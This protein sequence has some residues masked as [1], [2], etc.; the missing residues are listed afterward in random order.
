[1][2]AG[3]IVVADGDRWICERLDERFATE[4]YRV[5]LVNTA[6]AWPIWMS[7]VAAV[8]MA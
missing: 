1:M 5:M 6:D 8:P 4:G 7:S 2:R 3:I